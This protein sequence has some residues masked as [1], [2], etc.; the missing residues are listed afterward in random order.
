MEIDLRYQRSLAGPEGAPDTGYT[1]IQVQ[2][3]PR[4]WGR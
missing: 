2:L 4:L 3:L 1:T